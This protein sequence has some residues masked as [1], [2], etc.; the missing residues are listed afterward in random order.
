MFLNQGKILTFGQKKQGK[1]TITR[2]LAQIYKVLSRFTSFSVE[3][4]GEG[5]AQQIGKSILPAQNNYLLDSLASL[6]HSFNMFERW[7]LRY[8]LYTSFICS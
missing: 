7:H 4:G 3:R 2:I 5:F 6:A 8:I 1:N